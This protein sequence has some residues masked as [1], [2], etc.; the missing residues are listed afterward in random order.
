MSQQENLTGSIAMSRR[1]ATAAQAAPIQIRELAFN[2]NGHALEDGMVK[3]NINEIILCFSEKSTASIEATISKMKKDGKKNIYREEQTY[4]NREL[5]DL[6][7]GLARFLVIGYALRTPHEDHENKAPEHRKQKGTGSEAPKTIIPWDKDEPPLLVVTEITPTQPD[8]VQLWVLL[9]PMNGISS[10]YKI[11]QLRVFYRYEFRDATSAIKDR[12]ASWNRLVAA[13]SV[14]PG[15]VGGTLSKKQERFKKARDSS[16]I[17]MEPDQSFISEV[18]CLL[19]AFKK[20]QNPWHLQQL[21]KV[22]AEADEDLNLRPPPQNKGLR[23]FVEDEDFTIDDAG[24]VVEEVL[25]LWPE[26]EDVTIENVMKLKQGIQE[27]A[28]TFLDYRFIRGFLAEGCYRLSIDGADAVVTNEMICGIIGMLRRTTPE[29]TVS[30][31]VDGNNL[32]FTT[33]RQKLQEARRAGEVFDRELQKL[34]GDAT[35]FD[36]PND[37]LASISQSVDMD[38]LKLGFLGAV[39]HIVGALQEKTSG[40]DRMVAEIVEVLEQL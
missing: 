17:V 33:I 2:T 3:R 6:E 28:G 1:T 38:Q 13:V 29:S 27:G 10:P 30:V 34:C 9:F 21:T 24:D 15:E 35:I 12:A 23:K 31:S 8:G 11:G 32:L 37:A 4:T 20:S 36:T 22:L 26:V 16:R 18:L 19:G 39:R 40:L 25:E 5:G 7:P 14:R